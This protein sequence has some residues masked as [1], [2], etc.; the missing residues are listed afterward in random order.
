MFNI[1]GSRASN[2]S[3]LEAVKKCEKITGNKFNY[4]YINK[5]RS[6]D[7]KF[8]ITNMNKFKKKYP[9][10]KIKYAIDDIFK[11]MNEYEKFHQS[12]R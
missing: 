7:H 8:W 5:P 4:K 1:G 11:Q 12:K 6:G 10:W 9:K 3:I 2:I